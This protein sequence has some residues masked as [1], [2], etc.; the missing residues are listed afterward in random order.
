M[1]QH[2]YL[3]AFVRTR[4]DDLQPGLRGPTASTKHISVGRVTIGRV[5]SQHDYWHAVTADGREIRGDF[6]YGGWRRAVWAL[7]RDA[8]ARGIFPALP[9]KPRTCAEWLRYVASFHQHGVPTT[10]GGVYLSTGYWNEAGRLIGEALHTRPTL[11]VGESY[12]KPS[13]QI[14]AES[15]ATATKVEEVAA[16]QARYR[17]FVHHVREV[18]PGWREVTKVGYADNSTEVREVARDGTV[19]QRML[20]GP[21]GDA[22]F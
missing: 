21:G 20:V 8:E 22:C 13:D 1:S 6:G 7:V 19:R 17:R 11:K 14:V 10:P 12:S 3:A 9:E 4:D 18:A 5:V 16:F 15:K 2:R